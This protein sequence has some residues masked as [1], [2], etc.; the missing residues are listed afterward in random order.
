MRYFL[1]DSENVQQYKFIEELELNCDD[2]IIMLISER[3]KSIKAEDLK[4]FTSCPAEIEFEDVYTGYK[5][6][7]DFQLITNLALII[8]SDKNVEENSYFIVSNDNDFNMPVKYL[9]DKTQADINILKT[10]VNPCHHC[11][12]LDIDDSNINLDFVCKKL[13]LDNE[14]ISIIKE[15][16]A[17]NL[18]HNNLKTKYGDEGVKLY[19]QIK[20]YYKAL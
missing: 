9:K 5:N 20:P 3:S 10:D 4:R 6:A 8:S 18:L 1:I 12:K 11:S 7:M 13:N 19:K 15:S 17:L 16:K 14:A 2:K